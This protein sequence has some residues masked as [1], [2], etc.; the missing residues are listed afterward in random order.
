MRLL[1]A[2]ICMSLCL[3]LS[4]GY[5]NCV[6]AAAATIFDNAKF[7]LLDGFLEALHYT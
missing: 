2:V 7:Q 6:T 4:Y 1:S 5:G 3:S